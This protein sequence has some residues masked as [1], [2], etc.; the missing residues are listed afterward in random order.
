MLVS[1]CWVP[2]EKLHEIVQWKRLVLLKWNYCH[3]CTMKSF[4][5]V[6]MIQAM[7]W[8]TGRRPVHSHRTALGEL[9]RPCRPPLRAVVFLLGMAG[10]PRA[11][12]TYGHHARATGIPVE[13]WVYAPASARTG[14]ELM[15]A[16]EDLY[17]SPDFTLL[18]SKA[19]QSGSS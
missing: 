8:V 13:L 2:E 1:L 7:K 16:F 19:E 18:S 5:P 12:K 14:K 15:P 6:L 17:T 9:E 10:N 4:R 11:C 3:H